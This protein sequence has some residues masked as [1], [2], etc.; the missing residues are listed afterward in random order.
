MEILGAEKLYINA[1]NVVNNLTLVFHT[2]IVS[3]LKCLNLEFEGIQFRKSSLVFWKDCG[4]RIV[5]LTFHKCI[6]E[7]GVIF[8]QIL[9]NC[10]NLQYL[11]ID[12]TRARATDDADWCTSNEAIGKGFRMCKIQKGV[13]LATIKLQKLITLK[14][15]NCNFLNDLIYSDV[16]S[17]FPNVREI[18]LENI[19]ALNCYNRVD[20]RFYSEKEQSYSSVDIFSFSCVF[21][22]LKS[23]AFQIEKL[24]FHDI[25]ISGLMPHWLYEIGNIPNLR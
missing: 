23:K 24:S 10:V 11:H 21:N 18:F 20:R 15:R 2:L 8:Y 4:P 13:E 17:C 14:L 1:W 12:S 3:R 5:S 16:V 7:N 9:A 22:H 19:R 6:F 25:G